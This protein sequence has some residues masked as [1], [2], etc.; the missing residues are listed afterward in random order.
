MHP[1]CPLMVK[2]N[3]LIVLSFLLFPGGYAQQFVPP[4][5]KGS[6]G[7]A[8]HAAWL[9]LILLLNLSAIII[10]VT[11]AGNL[12]IKS[13]LPWLKIGLETFGWALQVG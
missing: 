6:S 3:V 7:W 10:A 1:A 11:V 8:P 9:V 4:T 5:A 13:S 2:R 12:V